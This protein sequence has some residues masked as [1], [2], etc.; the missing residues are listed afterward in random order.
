MEKYICA[1]NNNNNNLLFKFSSI[2]YALNSNL[3]FTNRINDMIIGLELVNELKM[4]DS[5]FIS[6]TETTTSI[7]ELINIIKH[8]NI[9]VYF[10]LLQEPI[11][12]YDIVELLLPYTLGLFI[13]NNIYVNPLIHIMPIGIR[14]C[15]KVVPGHKGFSHDYLYREG[16]NQRDKDI[17]C[18][19]CFSYSHNERYRCYNELHNKPFV[20]NLNDNEYEKQPSIHC[21]KVP[22]WINYEY[23]HKSDYVLCP[24]GC[25]EDTHRFY[26]AIYLDSIP[27]VK[28]TNTPFDNLYKIFPCMIVDDW[29]DINEGFLLQHRTQY[30]NKIKEFKFKYPNAFTDINSIYE[31]ILQT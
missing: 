21:G 27:I 11:V 30:K 17:L 25:G 19:L 4:G 23:T 29:C 6:I 1:K 8:K 5:I 10:Y 26:E 12:S 16:L 7:Y 2:G 18:L 28:R 24:R 22:V 14:D 31:M 3:M 13:Q 20:V 15:E 9:K